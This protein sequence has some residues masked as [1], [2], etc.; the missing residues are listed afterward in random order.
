VSKR[1]ALLVAALAIFAGG[2]FD[3]CKRA[4]AAPLPTPMIGSLL[5]QGNGG[6]P[7]CTLARLNWTYQDRYGNVYHCWL[8]NGI[9]GP[10]PEWQ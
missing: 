4:T 1:R 8:R 7:D 3:D 10:Y 6:A 2:F 5:D 9:Y